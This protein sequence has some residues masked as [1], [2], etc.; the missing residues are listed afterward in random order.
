MA[1][2]VVKVEDSCY[3][4]SHVAHS[5]TGITTGLD[6][7]K[8]SEGDVRYQRL[9]LQGCKLF[10]LLTNPKYQAGQLDPLPPT[11]ASFSEVG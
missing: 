10:A 4:C 11:W 2:S 9:H 8:A 6:T 1:Q 7:W 3:T 5:E